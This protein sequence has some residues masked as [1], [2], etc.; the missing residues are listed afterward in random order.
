MG[1]RNLTMV[2]KDGQIVLAQYGQWDG[3]PSGNGVVVLNFLKN[4]MKDN[5]AEQVDKLRDIKTTDIIKK[6]TGV[7]LEELTDEMDAKLMKENPQLSRDCGAGILKVIQ[8]NKNDVLM[9]Y[10][11]VDFAADSL[12]CEWAYLVDLDKQVLEVYK[13]FNTSPLDKDERF[14]FLTEKSEGEYKPIILVKKYSLLDLP[15]E[16]DF[17]KELEGSGEE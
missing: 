13:G 14:E 16:E 7:T 4:E 11:N 2:A 12:F 10:N 9:V 8:D 6:M 17:L 5:F 15:S 3:Y 1:T